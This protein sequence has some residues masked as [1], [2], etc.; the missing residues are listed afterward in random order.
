[1]SRSNRSDSP[2][3]SRSLIHRSSNDRIQRVSRGDSTGPESRQTNS[4][5]TASRRPT[6]KIHMALTKYLPTS[7]ELSRIERMMLLKERMAYVDKIRVQGHT[8]GKL[9]VSGN[10]RAVRGNLTDKSAS[11]SVSSSHTYGD[12]EVRD[13][14]MVWNGDV[15]RPTF[16]NARKHST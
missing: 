1:M 15:S 2:S 9:T 4:V 6:R 7:E 16:E 11:P 14:G 3:A 8:Y 10:A 5:R 12:C 13:N